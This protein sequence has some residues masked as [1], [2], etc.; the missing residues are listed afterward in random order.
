[1][2]GGQTCRSLVLWPSKYLV[3]EQ[4]IAELSYS[5]VFIRVDRTQ[6]T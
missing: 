4:D 5:T 6:T 1:M 2:L 3:P